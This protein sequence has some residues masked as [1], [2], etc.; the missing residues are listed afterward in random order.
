MIAY[1]KTASNGIAAMSFLAEIYNEETSHAGS[2]EIAKVRGISKAL[3]AKLLTTLS[4]AG[5]VKGT[6]G[7][8]G[9][10]TLAKA[11]NQIRLYDI[12][13]LFEKNDNDLICPFGPDWCGNNDRCPLHDEI[14]K[15]R[16]EAEA[17]LKGTT[18]QVFVDTDIAKARL[19]KLVTVS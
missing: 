11:P 9:G 18:L 1:G 3:V 13:V 6:P 12:I 10:Y 4:T 17:F 19:G 8:G 5:Y 15:Q 7:P 2:G 14:A 16:D